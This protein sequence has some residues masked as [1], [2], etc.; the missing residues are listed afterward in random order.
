MKRFS[1]ILL[2]V[3]LIVASLI[4]LFPFF[5]L[6]SSSFKEL[7]EIF[8]FP[9]TLWVKEPTFDNFTILFKDYEFYY[10][11]FNSFYISILAT[12]LSLFFCSLAG[13]AFAKYEF[14]GKNILFAIV[15]GSLMIP[16]ET[17]MVP[18]FILFKNLGWIDRHIGLILP[19][20]A[21]AFGIFF[22][23]QYMRNV[24]YEII[25]SGRIDGCREITIFTRLILPIIKPALASLGIIFFMNSWNN[26]L[27]PL[28]IL[29]SPEKMTL[30]VA[31]RS[32]V[33]G[34]RTP[35]HLIMAGSVV[36]ILPLLII[37]FL[38][39]NYFISGLSEGAVKS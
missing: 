5:W 34:I 38:F 14:K 10:P 29:K 2:Y 30:A 25:E 3:L 21:N 4:M 6:L 19:G 9:P 26:F 37:F 15:L 28:I 17:T 31:L 1:T 39:Q 13:F 8:V 33:Q 22:M 32:L 12:G 18:S 7:S 23:T 36:S 35:H 24:S 27:W 11:L 20:M 16:M